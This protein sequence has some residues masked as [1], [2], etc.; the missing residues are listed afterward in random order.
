MP[1]LQRMV[2][3]FPVISQQLLNCLICNEWLE[4]VVQNKIIGQYSMTFVFNSSSTLYRVLLYIL[5]FT[6]FQLSRN[7]VSNIPL[8]SKKQKN[9]HKLSL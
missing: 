3:N 4:T 8:L 6:V 9:S 7:S 5:S 2:E 1:G